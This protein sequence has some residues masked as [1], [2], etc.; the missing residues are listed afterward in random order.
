MVRK[1]LI[2]ANN[3]LILAMINLFELIKLLKHKVELRMVQ[4]T[5]YIE[6]YYVYS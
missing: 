1:S 2:Y 6:T 3:V 4:Y 5:E